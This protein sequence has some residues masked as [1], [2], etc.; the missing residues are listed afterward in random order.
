MRCQLPSTPLWG[1]RWTVAFR[2]LRA[3][4]IRLVGQVELAT[5]RTDVPLNPH[6][7]HE[8]GVAGPADPADRLACRPAPSGVWPGSILLPR[9]D[10]AGLRVWWDDLHPGVADSVTRIAANPNHRSAEPGQ[11]IRCSGRSQRAKPPRSGA[12]GQLLRRCLGSVPSL[13]MFLDEP[14][15]RVLLDHRFKLGDDVP[16]RHRKAVSSRTGLLPLPSRQLDAVPAVHFRALTSEAGSQMAALDPFGL[17]LVEI[18]APILVVGEA[19]L[20]R[21]R[22]EGR[23]GGLGHLASV[24][25]SSWSQDLFS[26]LA[27]A[28]GTPAPVE[29]GGQLGAVTTRRG[30]R[31]HAVDGGRQT[32][33]PPDQEGGDQEAAHGDRGVDREGGLDAVDEPAAAGRAVACTNEDV[34]V[35][36]RPTD[37][38][39]IWN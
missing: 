13:A 36:P 23:L 17:A 20:S 8:F 31:V 7:L 3:A 4:R 33:P 34:V 19:V 29:A 5:N 37:P 14:E 22:V 10:V 1:P 38:P 35:R 6:V 9:A 28:E 12:S 24:Q 2:A 26:L 30:A 15:V 18:P 11:Q 16:W 21:A 25:P 39:A 32:Q 27:I